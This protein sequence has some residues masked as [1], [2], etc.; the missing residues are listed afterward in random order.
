M[1]YDIPKEI[2]EEICR[3][4]LEALDINIDA[5]TAEQLAYLKHM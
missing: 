4:K 2:D 3:I 1:L 5:H